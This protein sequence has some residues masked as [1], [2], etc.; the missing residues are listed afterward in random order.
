MP[1]LN[2]RTASDVADLIP[3]YWIKKVRSDVAQTEFFSKMEGKEGSNSAIIAKENLNKEP[4]D[5][6]TFTVESELYGAGK[7]NETALAGYE[8]KAQI[9]QFGVPLTAYRHAEA[10]SA[11]ANQYTMVDNIVRAGGRLSR[12]LARKRDAILFGELLSANTTSLDTQGRTY[13][14]VSAAKVKTLYGG[15]ATSVAT[16]SSSCRFSLD[17]I[18]KCKL[19][20]IRQGARPIEVRSSKTGEVLPIYV[21]VIDEMSAF[22]LFSSTAFRSA[23]EATLPRS[24]DHPLLTGAIGMWNGVVIH[25]YNSINQGCHQ[26][27]PLRPEC[28]TKAGADSYDNT[29]NRTVICVGA[30]DGRDYT[31]H[32]PSSGKVNVNVSGTKYEMTYTAKGTY[33]FTLNHTITS[34]VGAGLSDGV[35]VTPEKDN[36]VCL[37]LGA[38]AACRAWGMKDT[39]ITQTYDYAQELGIGVKGTWGVR[40]M[41]DSEGTAPNYLL[42]KVYADTPNYQV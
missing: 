8:E 36:A 2:I 26:G 32:F 3:P 19:A 23:M 10:L 38:E 28:S 7:T 15:S 17:E 27:T 18:D 31:A 37:F 21:A 5:T 30:D 4:G 6:L 12:W 24:F 11:Y 25:V 34:V 33:Y 1:T 13:E 20:L 39:P 22:R 35:L 16:L 29:A 9:H 14:T 40:A 41:Q 42:L